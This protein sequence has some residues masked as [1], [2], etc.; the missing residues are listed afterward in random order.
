[1]REH[2]KI[3]TSAIMLGVRGFGGPT[4][5]LK[6]FSK[7]LIAEDKWA[8]NAE[9]EGFLSL[10]ALLPGP[11]SSQVGM[12]LGLERGGYLGAGLF[13]LGFTLPSAALM[14]LLSLLHVGN[15]GSNRLTLWLVKVVI[16]LVV[17]NAL[18]HMV[19]RFAKNRT[20]Q[21]IAVCSAIYSAAVSNPYLQLLGLIAGAIAGLIFIRSVP[22]PISITVHTISKR[23]ALLCL[24]V[25]LTLLVLSP[26][27][28]RD[29][30]LHLQTFGSFLQ[31]GALAFGGGHVILPLLQSRL[32]ST[33][34]MTGAIFARGY[35]LAQLMP[36]PLFAVAVYMGASSLGTPHG[37]PGAIEALIGIFLPGTLL[38]LSGVYFWKKW[39]ANARFTS[40]IEGINASVL[41]LL[42]IAVIDL[43][44]MK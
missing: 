33:H 40:A 2:L 17:L 24:G 10:A 14:Y 34:L 12:A 9:F 5:H 3:F 35:L 28:V 44:K 43:L 32:L 6:I 20:T 7:K 37:L 39:S 11:T 36:G 42:F 22:T 19:K 30:A 18:R 23:S 41:G 27:L 21:A 26:I 16:A 1:M 29:Q 31:I 4:A 15:L 38:M 25:A 8:S 13:W